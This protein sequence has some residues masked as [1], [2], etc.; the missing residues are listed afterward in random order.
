M[1]I[2][3]LIGKHE[4]LDNGDHPFINNSEN[5]DKF[6]QCPKCGAVKK[7]TK[8]DPDIWEEIAK[9]FSYTSNIAENK[10]KNKTKECLSD[11]IALQKYIKS[12]KAH[13]HKHTNVISAIKKQIEEAKDIMIKSIDLH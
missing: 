5:R 4:F 2:K 6:K 13:G 8:K 12:Y 1:N 7:F 9:I 10:E 3:C 11:L